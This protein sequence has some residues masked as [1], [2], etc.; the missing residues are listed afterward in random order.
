MSPSEQGKRTSTAGLQGL[1]RSHA[2]IGGTDR[3]GVSELGFSKG[4][5]FS[6]F[7]QSSFL[8]RFSLLFILAIS[9]APD[10][11][12]ASAGGD[13]V[14]GT[15]PGRVLTELA[16][17]RQYSNQRRSLGFQ[18]QASALAGP[19]AS[20]DEG[21]IAVLTDDGT[22]VTQPNSFD[23]DQRSLTFV[24]EAQGF[25]VFA[26]PGAFDPDAAASGVLL[27][28]PP[29]S[30]PANIGDDGVRQVADVKVEGPFGQGRGSPG[31]HLSVTSF[32][33]TT[34]TEQVA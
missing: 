30:N 10:A 31:G 12:A 19:A 9:V 4:R 34:N 29:A 17:H 14:C 33:R 6:S 18:P 5:I 21:H 8:Q 16:L 26:G 1:V 32:S 3:F 25:R 15:Y 27:N 11:S 7:L 23:L 24:P 20:V 13:M 2:R 22:L 28:S